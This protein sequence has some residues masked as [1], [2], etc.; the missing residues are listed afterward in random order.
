MFDY[1]IKYLNFNIFKSSGIDYSK[2]HGY[3]KI[4]F[5]REKVLCNIYSDNLI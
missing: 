1:N 2:L 3:N 4:A 5:I